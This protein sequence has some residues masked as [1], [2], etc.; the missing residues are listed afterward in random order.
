VTVSATAGSLKRS[1]T[2][3]LD[4]STTIVAV[5]D[6]SQVAGGGA[7]LLT[8]TLP[9]PAPTGGMKVTL[10]SDNVALLPRSS[11]TVPAGQSSISIGVT[12]A[13]VIAN[14]IAHLTAKDT[15]GHTAVLGCKGSLSRALEGCPRRSARCAGRF[16]VLLARRPMLRSRPARQLAFWG[17]LSCY[18]R[19]R[20]SDAPMVLFEDLGGFITGQVG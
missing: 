7:V 10:T 3:T 18:C 15:A 19:E 12:T 9:S 1:G 4:K 14:T 11:V 6:V 16:L 5:F 2:L 17:S 8:V 13:P 20:G